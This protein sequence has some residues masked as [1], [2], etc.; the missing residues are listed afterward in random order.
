MVV[1]MEL[2]L[3]ANKQIQ[4]VYRNGSYGTF[5]PTTKDIW[6]IML[7]RA[8]R[9]GSPCPTC[10]RFMTYQNYGY[11]ITTDVADEITKQGGRRFKKP[12]IIGKMITCAAC[13]LWVARIILNEIKYY[14]INRG[15]GD[16]GIITASQI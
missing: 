14:F 6:N 10:G 12:S 3:D 8:Y 7:G 13:R 5:R 9:N 2:I 16:L 15:D 1:N 4:L 11:T